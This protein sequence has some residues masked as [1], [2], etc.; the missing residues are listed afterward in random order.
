MF[1]T[2]IKIRVMF[3]VNN[4]DRQP[5]TIDTPNQRQKQYELGSRITMESRTNSFDI[6]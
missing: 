5:N 3:R 6:L 4:S 2:R 1:F